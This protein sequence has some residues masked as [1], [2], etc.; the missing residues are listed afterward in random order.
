MVGSVQNLAS[1][2]TNSTSQINPPTGVVASKIKDW[3]PIHVGLAKRF[4]PGAGEQAPVGKLAVKSSGEAAG[5][6]VVLDFRE[7]AGSQGSEVEKGKAVADKIRAAMSARVDNVDPEEF[8]QVADA[9]IALLADEGYSGA[10]AGQALAK[11]GDQVEQLGSDTGIMVQKNGSITLLTDS[12]SRVGCAPGKDKGK[13]KEIAPQSAAQPNELK[14]RVITK[15]WSENNA[16]KYNLA[17]GMKTTGNASEVLG[18]SSLASFARN[19]T[20]VLNQVASLFASHAW[21]VVSEEPDVDVWLGDPPLD[22]NLP[23]EPPPTAELPQAPPS[24]SEVAADSPRPS[25]PTIPTIPMMLVSESSQ[26]AKTTN[27]F[28]DDEASYIDVGAALKE[29]IPQP[30][31]ELNQKGNADL[32][33]ESDSPSSSSDP[34]VSSSSSTQ[35][36]PVSRLEDLN[37]DEMPLIVDDK[38]PDPKDWFK[39][40]DKLIDLGTPAIDVKFDRDNGLKHKKNYSGALAS[41]VN[42]VFHLKSHDAKKENQASLNALLDYVSNGQP[43]YVREYVLKG[44]ITLARD[45]PK[46]GA[47]GA[48]QT[49]EVKETLTFKDRID[50]GTFVSSKLVK[51]VKELAAAGRAEYIKQQ[52]Q[53]AGPVDLK[54]SA[55]IEVEDNVV[56]NRVRTW[57]RDEVITAVEEQQS[58]E[59]AN[60]AD[61]DLTEAVLTGA[62]LK[63]QG[64][65]AELGMRGHQAS[66][67]SPHSA[68]L[69][70]G[71]TMLCTD[72]PDLMDKMPD[73]ITAAMADVLTKLQSGDA[74]SFAAKNSMAIYQ[75]LLMSEHYVT[76]DQQMARQVADAYR[77]SLPP[78]FANE[79]RTR[80]QHAGTQHFAL[81]SE[82][83]QAALLLSHEHFLNLTDTEPKKSS[84]NDSSSRLTWANIPVY[85][86]TDEG[87]YVAEPAINSATLEKFPLLVAKYHTSAPTT[88]SEQLRPELDIQI[89]E[90]EN[91]A[92]L[93]P[94]DA[95]QREKVAR[96]TRDSEELYQTANIIGYTQGEGPGQR[97]TVYYRSK[98]GLVGHIT[99][100]HKHATNTGREPPSKADQY[101]GAN[102]GPDGRFVEGFRGQGIHVS[103]G[104]LKPVDSDETRERLSK[105]Q[106]GFPFVK[107]RYRSNPGAW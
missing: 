71:N 6:A 89:K 102:V 55:N 83:G 40:L 50:R 90:M 94:K 5:A 97:P 35:A 61:L 44:A 21:P 4:A 27:P 45:Q 46:A 63:H 66:T 107:Q 20:E 41:G 58:L 42:K 62:N 30:L 1:S 74:K 29:E 10:A 31:A 28:E 11:F 69:T 39:D 38:D 79:V 95:K 3:T 91:C 80:E 105:A 59:G 85:R 52:N 33:L 48:N 77:Q 23:H 54:S 76:G 43:P 56:V 98:S 34:V 100:E 103:R 75:L 64:S 96:L 82:D 36:D 68:F 78:E 22:A 60:L 14:T 7:I 47:H 13:A 57:T 73:T 92:R 37:Q 19:V 86:R 53:A 49:G 104:E 16:A 88:R 9:A 15:V 26:R 84:A 32:P 24:T 81:L 25:L 51:Q 70:K 87:R 67:V 18:R 72:W 8:Q 12:N 101:M 93:H 17:V 65:Q 106:D 2:A 99:Q